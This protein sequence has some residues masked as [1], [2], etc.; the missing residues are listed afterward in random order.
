MF[1]N[2][3]FTTKVKYELHSAVNTV[4]SAVIVEVGV[5]LFSHHEF[6]D[7]LLITKGLLIA[8]GLA[9]VRAAWKA[10]LMFAVSLLGLKVPT[11]TQ[12]QENV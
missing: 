11:P 7:P 8:G 5:Q 4:V 3:I 9:I 2:K 12:R 6:W 1:L 10:G